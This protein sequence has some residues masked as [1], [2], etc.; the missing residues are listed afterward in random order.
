MNKSY[1]LKIL[2]IRLVIG[3]VVSLG[4]YLA[5]RYLDPELAKIV[6]DHLGEFAAAVVAVVFGV[7]LHAFSANN[8]VEVEDF[9]DSE[10]GY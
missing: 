1:S 5:A 4:G 7:D 2:L 10:G 6:T 8:P 9:S 3:F